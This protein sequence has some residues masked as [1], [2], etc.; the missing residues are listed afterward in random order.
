MYSRLP[1]VFQNVR[2][3]KNLKCKLPLELLATRLV[4]RDIFQ[5]EKLPQRV[6]IA[7]EY[8]VCET[9]REQKSL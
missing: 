4:P 2:H 3:V 7:L 9:S 6:K 1:R 8:T 5:R